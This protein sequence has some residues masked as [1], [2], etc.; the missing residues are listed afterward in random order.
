MPEASPPTSSEILGQRVTTTPSPSRVTAG[1]G[2]ARLA[3]PRVHLLEA[4]DGT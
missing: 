4:K 3:A 2:L 1:E